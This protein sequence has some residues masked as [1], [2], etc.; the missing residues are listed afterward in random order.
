ME[1]ILKFN[2]IF[3]K[4]EEVILSTAIILMAV[5]LVA[6]VIGRMFSRSLTWAEEICALLTVITTFVG[7]SYCARMSCHITMTAVF[8]TLPLVGKKIF[9]F[10][11]TVGTSAAMCY[12]SYQAIR[13]IL[14]LQSSGRFTPALHIPLWIP[15]LM[16]PIGL[17]STAIQYLVTLGLNVRDKD[18]IHVG[19]ETVVDESVDMSDEAA[20]EALEDATEEGGTEE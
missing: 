19:V 20:K 10:I 3:K 7:T 9:Q 13:Y 2:R 18:I 15:Y 8:D 6:N 14:N 5:I 12:L 17:I 4:V 11:V 16:I 1:S